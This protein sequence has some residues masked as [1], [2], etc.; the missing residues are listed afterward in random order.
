MLN[1]PVYD[2][3]IRDQFEL[4]SFFPCLNAHCQFTTLLNLGSLIVGK[5]TPLPVYWHLLEF[6]PSVSLWACHFLFTSPWFTSTFSGTNP[7]LV[8][9]RR[10]LHF[11]RQLRLLQWR[12]IKP[13]SSLQKVCLLQWRTAPSYVG[14]FSS[15]GCCI[16]RISLDLEPT[17]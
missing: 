2:G 11:S 4:R 7:E 9:S 3:L 1:N 12:E 6:K 15:V 8:V 17:L 10:C 14:Q 13:A 16:T 5:P